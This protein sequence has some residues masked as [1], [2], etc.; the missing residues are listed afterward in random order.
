MYSSYC[1]FNV[2]LVIPQTVMPNCIADITCSRCR[3]KEEGKIPPEKF[4]SAEFAADITPLML[5]SHCNN[6]EMV[7]LLLDRGHSID[8][9]K[10]CE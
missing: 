6:Y 2:V 3:R 9:P 4:D 8:M 5:A 1:A 7:R 10:E